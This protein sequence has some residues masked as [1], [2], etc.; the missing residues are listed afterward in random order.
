MSRSK[1]QFIILL[2]EI[3]ELVKKNDN[4]LLSFKEAGTYLGF[5]TNYL[6]RLTYQNLIPH[7]KPTGKT[8]FFFKNELDEWIKGG[9]VKSEA[10]E[11]ANKV[12]RDPNQLEMELV[13]TEDRRLETGDR[14]RKRKELLIEF[15]LKRRR[16]KQTDFSSQQSENK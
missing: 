4:K 1:N 12:T 15:P 14:K 16:K 11:E 7:Y 5:S 2:K 6:Y 3:K 9:N 13:K 8:I 10:G